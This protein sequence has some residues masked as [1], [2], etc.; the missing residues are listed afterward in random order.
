MLDAKQYNALD[1]AQ[2]TDFRSM[3]KSGELLW[4][5]SCRIPH[6]EAA[7]VVAT[8]PHQFCF[9]DA[10]HSPL[11]PTLIASLIK[12]IQ[13]TSNGSMVP[14][15][16]LAPNM[17]DLINYVLLA[18]AGGIVQP[19]V[20]NAEQARQLVG[21]AK[22]PPI[23]TRS[24]PPLALFGKQ[25]RTKPG[26][27]VY[28]VWNNHAAIFA[29]IEDVEGVENVE[30]IAA[31]P[32][33]DALMVGAGD[34]RCSVGLEVG[35]QDGD[36]PVFLAALDKIQRAADKNGLAVLGFAMT[37][38]ILERRLKL[39]WKAFIVHS[40]GAGV[41]KSGVKSFEDNV[42]LAKVAGMNGLNGAR[43]VDK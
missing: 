5:T 33:I 20:Q 19:H 39:G 27:T 36:E 32:G 14:Y 41:F 1:L 40:D 34:L 13:Y 28:D 18:G 35:S 42:R 7:R 24:Y 15:V 8:L 4:G 12:T 10:E 22:F 16:R 2:P 21:L 11:N 6:E 3:L 43:N 26:E 25:T 9:L 30:E 31:V 17:P 38:E 23:G 29:Q 37:P